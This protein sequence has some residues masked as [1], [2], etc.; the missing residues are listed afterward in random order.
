LGTTFEAEGAE[1]RLI[2]CFA[3]PE[4][5]RHP[6]HQILRVVEGVSG[7]VELEME[8]APRFDYG[9]VAPWRRPRRPRCPRFRAER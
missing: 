7:Y 9:A 3:L 6:H 8:I 4:D 5:P 1:A 2:D